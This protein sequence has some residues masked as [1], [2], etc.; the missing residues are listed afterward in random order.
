MDRIVEVGTGS[1][2]D[3]LCLGVPIPSIWLQLG[4][5]SKVWER[6][7][8]GPGSFKALVYVGWYG[9]V[10]SRAEIQYREVLDII[11]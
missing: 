8:C 1:A 11:S 7:N 9:G 5:P 6:W 4:R 2:T 10:L 3:G